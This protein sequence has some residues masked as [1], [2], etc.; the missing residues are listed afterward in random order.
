M[1]CKHEKTFIN[2]ANGIKF[3]QCSNCKEDLGNIEATT[4]TPAPLP[5][6]PY[7]ITPSI[8]NPKPKPTPKPVVW[9]K[10]CEHENLMAGGDDWVCLDC[11]K[12]FTG[13]L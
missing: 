4:P 9:N 3:L 7:P 11:G 13:S 12:L 2:I 1:S 8:G 6:P 5:K 10:K